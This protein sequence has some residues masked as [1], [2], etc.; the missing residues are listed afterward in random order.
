MTGETPPLL[1]SAMAKKKNK[2][3]GQHNKQQPPKNRQAKPKKNKAAPTQ[4]PA[5]PKNVVNPANYTDE[6][7]RKAVIAN[8]EGHVAELTTLDSKRKLQKFA[9]MDAKKYAKE[10]IDS[11]IGTFHKSFSRQYA[12]KPLAKLIHKAMGGGALAGML[13]SG[14][15]RLFRDPLRHVIEGGIHKVNK[16]SGGMLDKAHAKVNDFAGVIA[17]KAQQ[18]T[19][20]YGEAAGFLPKGATERYNDPKKQ[21]HYQAQQERLDIRDKTINKGG[22][23]QKTVEDYRKGIKEARKAG[24]HAKADKLLKESRSYSKESKKGI[25]KSGQRRKTSGDRYQVQYGQSGFQS[26]KSPGK[27]YVN[28]ALSNMAGTLGVGK[29]RK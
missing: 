4:P 10:K 27:G 25:L 6:S 18:G 15:A 14:M 3:K 20:K 23:H 1:F 26:T 9:S 11:A 12:E 24:D 7:K 16:A 19:L 21:A 5:R 13:S 8:P 29:K 22:A 28:K 17:H 2:N